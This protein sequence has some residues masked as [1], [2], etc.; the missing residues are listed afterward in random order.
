[1][2]SMEYN[3]TVYAKNG[4]FL[5]NMFMPTLFDAKLNLNED[6]ILVNEVYGPDSIY[7]NGKVIEN[8]R[9]V[10]EEVAPT[11]I[12]RNDYIVKL[13]EKGIIDENEL[14]EVSMGRLPKK[15]EPISESLPQRERIEFILWWSNNELIWDNNPNT[16]LIKERL[17]V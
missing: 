14:I 11:F 15:F 13:V 1:M 6:E 12:R 4:E 3:Y 9:T 7:V 8:V 5:R 2:I 17:G 10:K 16:L